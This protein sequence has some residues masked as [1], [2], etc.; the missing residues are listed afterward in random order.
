MTPEDKNI[1]RDLGDHNA[2]LKALEGALEAMTDDVR[3]IR[4]TVTGVKGSW[5]M[6]VAIAS[7]FAGALAILAQK[8]WAFFLTVPGK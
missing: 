5:K 7:L 3:E 2:R 4:D 8:L 1:Y 6:L